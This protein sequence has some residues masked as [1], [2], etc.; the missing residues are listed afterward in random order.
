MSPAAL[1]GLALFATPPDLGQ[2]RVYDPL[3]TTD[4]SALAKQLL[5]HVPLLEVELEPTTDN[6]LQE[7]PRTGYAAVLSPSRV[8]CLSFLV[9][10]AK[11]VTLVGPKGRV[12]AR[13]LYADDETRVAM[14]KPEGDIARAGLVPV[15]G[16]VP[17]SAREVDMPVFALVST[18]ELAG[19][20]QGVLTQ[21]GKLEEY[22]GFL[23]VDLK[24][25]RGMP[26]FDQRARLLGFS[27]VVA[28]DTDRF[29]IVPPEKLRATKTA[30]GAARP[31][32]RTETTPWWAK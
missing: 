21:L 23:R 12:E 18:L 29:M 20:A 1:L 19:V 8:I 4:Q 2:G 28:W 22:E 17:P 7:N 10:D 16:W 30:T 31:P 11:K 24:L 13:V 15:S 9:K 25:H 6:L 26:V 32:Q 27:R 5:L 14:L 3:D